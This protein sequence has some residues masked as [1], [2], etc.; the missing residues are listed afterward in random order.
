METSVQGFSKAN[1]SLYVLSS[2]RVS[3]CKTVVDGNTL[4]TRD[5][6]LFDL[7]LVRIETIWIKLQGFAIRLCPLLIVPLAE[8]GRT[9]IAVGDS[10]VWPILQRP[11]IGFFSL[12]IF[13][14]SIVD[15]SEVV[16]RVRVSRIKSK[17]SLG[18]SYEPL[19]RR[20]DDD[21]RSQ[22]CS[23]WRRIEASSVDR[24][25]SQRHSFR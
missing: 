13:A 16:E 5:T 6:L 23:R 10:R 25:R 14:L 2:H 17:R 22:S 21:M 3:F 4:V 1:E 11:L 9:E 7:G 8:V 12:L 15:G 18:N 20:R 19:P 24:P